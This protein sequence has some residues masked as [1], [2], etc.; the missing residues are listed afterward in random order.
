MEIPTDIKLVI[1]REKMQL[2]K[3]TIYSLDLEARVAK[4]V[5][6]DTKQIEEQLKKMLA[7]QDEYE[8]ILKELQPQ[9]G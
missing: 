6:N 1:V 5:G 8:A 3:N 4:R 7:M 9:E 2:V